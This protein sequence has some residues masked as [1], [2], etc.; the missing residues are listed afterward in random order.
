MNRELFDYAALDRATHVDPTA[1]KL[2]ERRVQLARRRART[3]AFLAVAAISA[4]I[5]GTGALTLSTLDRSDPRPSKAPDTSSSSA[6]MSVAEWQASIQ[7]YRVRLVDAAGRE[8]AFSGARLDNEKREIVLYGTGELPTSLRTL[9]D[10]H[11]SQVS[12]RWQTVDFNATDY[13][14]AADRLRR[15][16]TEIAGTEWNGWGPL[17]LILHPEYRPQEDRLLARA[18]GMTSIPITIRYE[19]PVKAG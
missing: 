8:P 3:R 11:P 18:E 19:E 7:A 2:I 10:D 12:V 6:E 13:A 4:L 1:I 16:M 14:E 17:V 5:I 9:V 15:E